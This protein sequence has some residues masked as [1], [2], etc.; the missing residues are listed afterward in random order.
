MIICMIHSLEFNQCSFAFV[1]LTILNL[2]P[3]E[4]CNVDNSSPN[5]F[6]RI[7]SLISIHGVENYFYFA[8]IMFMYLL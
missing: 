1:C 4:L 8:V 5:N 6:L 3:V 7:F 2:L